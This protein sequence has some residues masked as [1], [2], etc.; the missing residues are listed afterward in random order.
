MSELEK[1]IIQLL[2]KT[3]DLSVNQIHKELE[4][5]ENIE[6]TKLT[7]KLMFEDQL[8]GKLNSK[9]FVLDDRGVVFNEV[10][11]LEAER[12]ERETLEVE[13]KD[14]KKE[15]IMENKEGTT[16]SPKLNL[17]LLEEDLAKIQAHS[18]NRYGFVPDL[19]QSVA[20]AIKLAVQHIEWGD[21]A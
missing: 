13:L 19:D 20:C 11:R 9:Y 5:A 18:C 1:K 16:Y 12:I 21:A 7:C 4:I 3:P 10:Q 14:I 6:E 15:K 2:I 17:D 8:L